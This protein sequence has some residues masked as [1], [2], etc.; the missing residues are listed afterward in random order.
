MSL[1]RAKPQHEVAYQELAALLKK[2]ADAG[3]LSGLE[4]L[5]V[6]ANMV[7]KMVALQD[8]RLVSPKLAMEVVAQ[9][10]EHGNRQVLEQLEQSAGGL[11]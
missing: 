7:G 4:I 3:G 8:Q 5:A 10:I 2:H 1:Y 9:N 11:A 6:A